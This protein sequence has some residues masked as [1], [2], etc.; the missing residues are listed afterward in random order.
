MVYAMAIQPISAGVALS[1]AANSGSTGVFDSV[2]LKMASPPMSAMRTKKEGWAGSSDGGDAGECSEIEGMRKI[3]PMT[4]LYS[5]PLAPSTATIR[6]P[7]VSAPADGVLPGQAF[8]FAGLAERD[9]RATAVTGKR[10][11]RRL[12]N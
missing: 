10:A 3:A 1:E 4:S 2:E 12:P 9:L 8:E 5:W 6:R 7:A 11:A